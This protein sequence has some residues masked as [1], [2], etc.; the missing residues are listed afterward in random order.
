VL[1]QKYRYKKGRK[2]KE[3][4]KKE[5]MSKSGGDYQHVVGGG[6]KN[7]EREDNI[8]CDTRVC[9]EVRDNDK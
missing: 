7:K 5:E 3:T 4:E 2:R 1:Q 8:S 9:N 6:T